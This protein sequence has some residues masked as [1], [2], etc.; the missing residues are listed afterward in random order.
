[1]KRK[2][3]EAGSSSFCWLDSTRGLEIFLRVVLP[4]PRVPTY[5]TIWQRMGKGVG[6]SISIS[7]AYNGDKW[8]MKMTNRRISLH[9][10]IP[11][12]IPNPFGIFHEL[13]VFSFFPL[14]GIEYRERPEAKSREIFSRT[15]TSF[16]LLSKG[17]K[18]DEIDR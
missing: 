7:T 14:Q 9:K 11:K 12:E 18:R 13:Q 3:R 16:R 17:E 2:I 6:E 4:F 10:R 15:C 5:D 1:M 8:K